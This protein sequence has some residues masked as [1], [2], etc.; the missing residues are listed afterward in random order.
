MKIAFFQAAL[1]LAGAQAVETM[2]EIE[3]EASYWPDLLVQTA[4]IVDFFYPSNEV[5]TPA[6]YLAEIAAEAD[7]DAD[8]ESEAEE[9]TVLAEVDAEAEVPGEKTPKAVKNA[10]AAL[11]KAKKAKTVSSSSSSEGTA[12]SSEAG[13]SSSGSSSSSSGS[14]DSSS[15]TQSEDEAIPAKKPV[16]KPAAA[17]PRATPAGTVTK[18]IDG[19]KVTHGTGCGCA[20][21]TKCCKK[22]GDPLK[23]AI[24]ILEADEENK[25][26]EWQP[27][28][29]TKTGKQEPVTICQ[30][31]L[32]NCTDQELADE[33]AAIDAEL[34][35]DD[36]EEQA[37]EAA[38]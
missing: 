31:E 27:E 8:I 12:S 2:A 22:P 36:L 21:A 26:E 37:Y 34:A 28:T 5:E 25:K 30:A 9:P 6:T 1:L 19:L 32:D 10:V 13:S 33:L 20:Q 29:S 14:S 15:S 18:N 16:V 38:W 3:Q 11:A 17:A 35:A 7:V 4:S 24:G 23:K